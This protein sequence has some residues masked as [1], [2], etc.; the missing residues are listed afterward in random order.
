MQNLRGKAL[1]FPQQ[2]QQQM[3]GA[4]VPVRQPLRFFG[5]IGQHAL[6]FIAQRK[7]DRGRDLLPNRGVSFDL[8]ADG[9]D[10][11]VRAQEPIGQG[12]VFAQESE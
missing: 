10:R 7:I 8:L 3:L 1:F 4:D 2:T 5:G 11:G 9:L 12:F 6:A